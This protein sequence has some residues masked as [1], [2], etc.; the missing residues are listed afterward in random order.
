[1]TDIASSLQQ[2]L[3]SASQAERDTAIARLRQLESLGRGSLD[4][5]PR[6]IAMPLAFSLC[7][8]VL[9]YATTLSNPFMDIDIAIATVGAALI[10]LGAWFMF[11]PRGTR[12]TLTEQGVR[13]KDVLLPWDSIEECRITRGYI[14]G[15]PLHTLIALQHVAGF[16]PPQLPLFLLLGSTR[17]DRKSGRH[18]TRL[19]LH[20]GAKGMNSRKLAQR[21]GDFYNAAR[22]RAELA[23]MGAQ[24]AEKPA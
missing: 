1:M 12:L 16:T 11:G 22:A 4:I 13:V 2:E 20:S 14:G 24:S 18:V 5:Q 10:A 21:I 8:C 23:H 19:M 9:I 3:T 17:H 6:A 15:L 7:G